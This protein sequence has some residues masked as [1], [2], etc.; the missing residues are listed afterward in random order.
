MD[1]YMK[2]NLQGPC[3]SQTLEIFASLLIPIERVRT[4]FDMASFGPQL[5]LDH[6]IT[7]WQ[8]G[9]SHAWYKNVK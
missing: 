3:Q 7:P 2:Y 8:G 9:E 6:C 1:N 5:W 4:V